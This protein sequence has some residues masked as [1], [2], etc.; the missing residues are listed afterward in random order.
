MKLLISRLKIKIT[1]ITD[2]TNTDNVLN[3]NFDNQSIHL[4]IKTNNTTTLD[5]LNVNSQVVPF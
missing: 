3:Y 1:K 2:V 5:L 4:N